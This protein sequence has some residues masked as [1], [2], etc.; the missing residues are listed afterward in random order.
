MLIYKGI[1]ICLMEIETLLIRQEAAGIVFK[2]ELAHE[3]A[4]F[5][6]NAKCLN[7]E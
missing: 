1:F 2:A 5:C 4:V 6:S 3:K 7:S